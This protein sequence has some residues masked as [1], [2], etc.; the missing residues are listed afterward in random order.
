VKTI[1]TEVIMDRK[2]GLDPEEVQTLPIWI[3]LVAIRISV[4]VLV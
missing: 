4:A 1:A 3:A 2:T